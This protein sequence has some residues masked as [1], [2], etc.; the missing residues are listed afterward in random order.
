LPGPTCAGQAG[1]C[2]PNKKGRI[3]SVK[4][5]KT[6]SAHFANHFVQTSI[7]AFSKQT[8]S[9]RTPP[10]APQRLQQLQVQQL[11]L[12]FSSERICCSCT[13]ATAATAERGLQRALRAMASCTRSSARLRLS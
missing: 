4:K 11:W 10:T 8:F 12:L 3:H 9:K 13:P 5:K 6:A 2:R 7:R 1:D